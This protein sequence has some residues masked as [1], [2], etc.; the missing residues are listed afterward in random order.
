MRR[1][2]G[3]GM[4]SRFVTGERLE[5]ALKVCTCLMTSRLWLTDTLSKGNAQSHNLWGDRVHGRGPEFL[6]SR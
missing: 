1:S 5:L 2:V 4:H 3:E 6:S